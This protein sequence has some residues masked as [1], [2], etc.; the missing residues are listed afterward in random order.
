MTLTPSEAAQFMA[1]AE[2]M[3]RQAVADG[4]QSYGAVIVRNGKVVGLGPSRV[5]TNGDPTAHAEMEAIRD[6]ASRLKTQDL[7]GCIMV[8]TSKPC[9]MCET[10]AYWARL[11]GLIHGSGLT[12]GGRPEYR[13]C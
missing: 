8:S 4:D 1:K 10:A 6:A 2:E 13:R 7:S 5:V 9:P 12:D 11:D 3:R